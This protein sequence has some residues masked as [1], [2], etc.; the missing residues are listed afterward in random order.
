MSAA[1][2]KHDTFLTERKADV[3]DFRARM[4]AAPLKHAS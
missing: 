1:P 2:L 4:S 3:L